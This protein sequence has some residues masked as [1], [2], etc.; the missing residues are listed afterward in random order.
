MNSVRGISRAP[1]LDRCSLATWQ[2]ISAMSRARHS[3]TNRAIAT[4]D[5]SLARL[6]TPDATLTDLLRRQE[7][8]IDTASNLLNALLDISRL[9]SGAIEPD[10]ARWHSRRCSGN[11]NGCAG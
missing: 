8:A 2:S 4:F 10:L 3:S 7:Q 5:A 11:W 6:M 9:E 1:R